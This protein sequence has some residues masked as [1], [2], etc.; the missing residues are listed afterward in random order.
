M[1]MTKYE[2][3][4]KN[5]LNLPSYANTLYEIQSNEDLL[6]VN[7]NKFDELLI[8]GECTNL[9][10]P[11]KLNKKVIKYKNTNISKI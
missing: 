10:L 1:K 7:Y 2:I 5:S 3:K 4:I 8:I 6:K 11:T 9:V